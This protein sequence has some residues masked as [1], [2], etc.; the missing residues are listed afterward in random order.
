MNFIEK[1]YNN[2]LKVNLADYKNIG[3]NLDINMVILCLTVC[4]V[5]IFI[6]MHKKQTLISTLF[7]KIKRTEAFGAENAVTLK[8]L[9]LSENSFRKLLTDRQG[10]LKSAITIVGEKKLTYEEYISA[11]KA[12]KT[13]SKTTEHD[14]D[15]ITE[16]KNESAAEISILDKD[17]LLSADAKFY[18]P[19]DNE[20]VVDRILESNNATVTKTL[21]SCVI[22][23][24]VGIA[25][26]SVMPSLLSA[27]NSA[28]A[29]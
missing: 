14:S 17:G 15:S 28:L 10:I 24:V 2:Y 1:I 5:I 8:D 16:N 20:N 4:L 11:Q 26:I 25:L 19:S 3:I 29:K 23:T 21:I 27:I 18:V 12:K 9:G 22:I 7:K 6:L 13:K